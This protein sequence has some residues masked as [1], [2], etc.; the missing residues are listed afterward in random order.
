MKKAFYSIILSCFLLFSFPSCTPPMAEI[1]K[2]IDPSTIPSSPSL[3]QAIK[4]ENHWLGLFNAGDTTIKVKADKDVLPEKP[5]QAPDLSKIQKEPSKFR[6]VSVG[7]GL[8]A[9]FRD[10]GLYREGQLTAFPNLIAGQMK[11]DFVQPLFS[12]AEGNGTGYKTIAASTG[13]LVTFNMVSNNLGVSSNGSETVYSPF[14]GP[15][16]IDQLAFPEISRGLQYFRSSELVLDGSYKYL[17]RVVT[18]EI[19]TKFKSP[20]EW[21]ESQE[22]DLFIFELGLSDLVRYLSLAGGGGISSLDAGYVTTSPEFLLMR[23][24]SKKAKG[25]MLNVPN[26]TESPYFKQITIEKVTK[27]GMKIFVQ[28]SS[29]SERFR[30]FDSSI[31]RLLPTVTVEKLFKGELTGNVYL[32]DTDVLSKADGDDEVTTITPN[33]YNQNEVTRIAKELNWPIV[34]LNSLYKRIQ[35]GSYVTDDGIA[36]NPAWPRGGNFF[37][38]DGVYPTAFGQAVITNEVIKTLNKHYGLQIQ[39]L[40]TRFFMGK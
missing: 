24:V 40:Q 11:V 8:S 26:A 39:L 7:G 23:S 30:P 2:A 15:N 33:S 20:R 37:S 22:G 27:L 4:S 36:V 6:L 10:G 28:T 14:R 29:H 25:V 35:A 9:G 19:T 31:D 13:P 1:S 38:A 12:E 18:P 34:D 3:V 21:I 17:N 32:K 5:A 16:S